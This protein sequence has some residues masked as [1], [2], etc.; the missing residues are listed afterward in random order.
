MA[1]MLWVED[2]S[3]RL[4]RVSVQ[5]QALPWAFHCWGGDGAGPRGPKGDRQA[6]RSGPQHLQLPQNTLVQHYPGSSH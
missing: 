5:G 2:G 3:C 6:Q 1:V 4:E